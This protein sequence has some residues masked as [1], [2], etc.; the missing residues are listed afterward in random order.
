VFANRLLLIFSLVLVPF[1]GV[2]AAELGPVD[3]SGFVGLET[4]FFTES[5]QHAGQDNDIQASVI[6]NPEFRYRTEDRNHQFSFIP[7]YREDSKDHERS[8]FDVREAYWLWVG[9]E[10]EVLTGV[11][12]V[13]WGVAE[14]RHLVNIINQSDGVEDLDGE[15][16]LGQPMVNIATQ[17]D[18]GRVDLFVLPG[19]R[20]R[21]FPG[22]EGRFRS[23]VLVDTDNAMYQSGAKEKHIDFAARY[24]HY[25]GSWDVG[26]SYFNG[27]DREPVLA[28]NNAGTKLVPTY[29]LINQGGVDVQYTTDAWLWK[30]EGIVR[31]GQG[32]TFVASVGGFEYTFYQIFEKDWDLGVLMEYQYDGRDSDAPATGADGDVFA[33]LR[34][35]LNDIQD[36]SLLAGFSVDHDTGEQFYNLEA[37]RRLADDYSL[38]LRARFF[39]GADAGDFSSAIQ[40]DDYIQLRLAR[41]F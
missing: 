15:D 36:T 11:N 8:H 26:L 39:A 7:F 35:A 3:V 30:F 22:E 40:Q 24:S 9:D 34:L 20:E 14:S 17:Q 18:W 41:Y 23:A 25:F 4:R 19:F 28:L 16:Y 38:E 2:R 31:E 33:G 32:D 1:T 12:K 21:T 37:E 10:W 5:A 29:N 27:T 6:F 13:F